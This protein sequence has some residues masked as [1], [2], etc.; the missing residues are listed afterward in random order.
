MTR[1]AATLFF[2]PPLLAILAAPSP[3]QEPTPEARIYFQSRC[4]ACHTIGG[5]RLVGPD[6]KDATARQ[7]RAWLERFIRDPG[8]LI[9]AGD[10]YAV[11]L[12]ADSNQVRMTT[13]P[14][15]SA[16]MATQL[17]DLIAF[18][19]SLE[20]SAYRGAA[21]DLKPITDADIARGER[22]FRGA[23]ALIGGGPPCI[24]CHS[25]AAIGGFG[26][27]RLGPDLTEAYARLGGQAALHAWLS[28]PPSAV[29]T[30]V[31]G[32]R[33]LS[34][35]EI[36]GLVS[37]LQKTGARAP[38]KTAAASFGFVLSGAVLA[39]ALLALLNL[40]WRDRFRAVRK[41]MVEGSRR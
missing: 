14:D 32:P 39:G 38:G 12:L 15:L 7:D 11:K 9:D 21:A 13:Y 4:V 26:G 22:L 27:G 36:H 23:E 18:E 3:A 29:M 19:S 5:G 41:P 25:V 33:P 28:A 2:L 17:V 31:F 40:I 35:D 8:A 24:S 20:H 37:F 1:H 30:P 6:L 34:A 16:E 10:A